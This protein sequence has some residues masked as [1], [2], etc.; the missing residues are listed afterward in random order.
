IEAPIE[1]VIDRSSRRCSE[2]NAETAEHERIERRPA[3]RSEEHARDRREHDEQHDSGL[4][5]LV[6]IAPRGVLLPFRSHVHVE[7]NRYRRIVACDSTWTGAKA[8]DA[9]LEDSSRPYA[10][11]RHR[12]SR[13]VS[14]RSRATP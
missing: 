4:A 9:R 1:H 10:R 7:G 12:L 14:Q 11:P 6:E 13:A 8:V 5:E 2:G 3:G